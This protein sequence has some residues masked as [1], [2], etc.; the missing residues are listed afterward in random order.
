M[1]RLNAHCLRSATTTGLRCKPRSTDSFATGNVPAGFDGVVTLLWAGIRIPTAPSP[2]KVV[3]LRLAGN[4]PGSAAFF[5]DEGPSSV[6]PAT[7]GAVIDIVAPIST[8]SVIVDA[9]TAMSEEE[10]REV[11][12]AW[13]TSLEYNVAGF[14]LLVDRG[15][16]LTQINAGL[17]PSQ[18]TNSTAVVRYE[19]SNEVQGDVFYLQV[20]TASGETFL[21][22]P[23]RLDVIPPPVPEDARYFLPLILSKGMLFVPLVK[24]GPG[25]ERESVTD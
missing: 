14:N 5:T 19:Y 13:T 23:A 22:G 7:G 24:I 4:M 6:G 8:Q 2:T 3:R 11:D 25:D 1:V 21:V 20:V 16:E 15:G 10:S 9:F 12:F 18:V 17:I